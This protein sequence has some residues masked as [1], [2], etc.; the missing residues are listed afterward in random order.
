MISKPTTLH[1]APQRH[2][3]VYTPL[4]RNLTSRLMTRAGRMEKRSPRK[5]RHI[6]DRSHASCR[7][8][9]WTDLNIWC[10]FDV[11]KSGLLIARL[12]SRELTSLDMNWRTSTVVPLSRDGDKW[13]LDQGRVNISSP[14]LLYLVWLQV[15]RLQ[16]F[17]TMS[18]SAHAQASPHE[19]VTDEPTKGFSLTRYPLARGFSFL[20]LLGSRSV[21]LP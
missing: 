17:S 1:R 3:R 2:R 11:F 5:R 6:I 20:F 18:E 15:L 16:I 14:S 10:T 21:W 8:P 12:P 9:D 4:S 13:T 7:N 19:A